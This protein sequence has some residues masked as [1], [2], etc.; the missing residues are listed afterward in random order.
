MLNRMERIQDVAY[1][2]ASHMFTS[3]LNPEHRGPK[4]RF[5]TFD[6]EGMA[7]TQALLAFARR[8]D[9]DETQT[10]RRTTRIVWDD[11]VERSGVLTWLYRAKTSMHA[12]LYLEKQ[13]RPYDMLPSLHKAMTA[14]FEQTLDDAMPVP[15]PDAIANAVQLVIEEGHRENPR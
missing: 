10:L 1:R 4:F 11:M 7:E 5:E 15:D 9:A 14:D 13:A 3:M 12:G 2:T 8:L 6:I